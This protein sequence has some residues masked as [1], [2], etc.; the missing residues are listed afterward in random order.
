MRPGGKGPWAR[1]LP[2][3]SYKEPMVTAG[4]TQKSMHR[5]RCLGRPGTRTHSAAPHLASSWILFLIPFLG[6][7]TTN[8]KTA[9]DAIFLLVVLAPKNGKQ[10]KKR[11]EFPWMLPTGS[12]ALNQVPLSGSLPTLLYLNPTIVHAQG[13]GMHGTLTRPSKGYTIGPTDALQWPDSLAK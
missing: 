11:K 9:S 5:W 2:A 6:A 8:K 3:H 10:S 13:P 7:R 4:P 12:I 1:A